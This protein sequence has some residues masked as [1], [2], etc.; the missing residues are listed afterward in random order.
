MHV[1][2]SSVLYQYVIKLTRIPLSFGNVMNDELDGYE[3]M[4][5]VKLL[6]SPG[7]SIFVMAT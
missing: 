5:E 4:D 1:F 2:W 7:F 6:Q 3:V